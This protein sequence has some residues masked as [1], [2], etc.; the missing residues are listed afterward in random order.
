MFIISQIGHRS[1]SEYKT[2][3][4]GYKRDAYCAAY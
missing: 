2:Q 3:S 1:C 4:F